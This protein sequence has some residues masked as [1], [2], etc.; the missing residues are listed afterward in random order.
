MNSTKIYRKQNTRLPAL[1]PHASKSA[2]FFLTI[3]VFALVLPFFAI[4]HGVF[5]TAVAISTLI[6]LF[7]KAVRKESIK[8]FVVALTLACCGVI[9]A[10]LGVQVQF[11]DV[12]TNCDNVHV[13]GSVE[14]ISC[15]QD[16]YSPWRGVVQTL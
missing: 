9:V 12:R 16:N 7:V 5:S 10:L 11:T 6:Q 3:S 4:I 14:H 15:F 1:P 8:Y 2:F 13:R